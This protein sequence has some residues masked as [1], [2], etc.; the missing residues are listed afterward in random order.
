[1]CLR[2]AR[3]INPTKILA[4]NY[5]QAYEVQIGCCDCAECRGQKQKE[6]HVRAYWQARE[7]IDNDGWMYFDTLTYDNQHLPHLSDFDH[8]VKRFS[9][10][11]FSC[12]SYEEIRLF[13]VNL[14]RQLDYYGY[15]SKDNLQYFVSS[16]YGSDRD[17]LA[18]G[19][20]K[21]ATMRPHYHILF[22]VK[23][24]CNLSPMKLSY[25]I[26]KCWQK[27]RTD[28]YMYHPEDS[29]YV[30]KHTYG[31]QFCNDDL[32]IRRV[33][34]YVTKYVLKD[35]QYNSMIINRLT[36]LYESIYGEDFLNDN[37]H[38]KDFETIY[39]K[40]SMF[41]RQ[42]HGFGLYLLEKEDFDHL[43]DGYVVLPDEFKVQKKYKLP[44]YY[45]YHLW[46]EK[47]RDKNGKLKYGLSEDGVDH[48]Y[49]MIDKNIQM[50]A[51]RMEEWTKNIIG[52]SFV[53]DDMFFNVK[54]GEYDLSLSNA[55]C[56]EKG[57]KLY[58]DVMKLMGGR[59]WVDYA[60]YLLLYRGRIRSEVSC[61]TGIADDEY[62]VKNNIVMSKTK[63]G[64]EYIAEDRWL[65]NYA[66]RSDRKNFRYNFVTT[67]DLGNNEEGYKK[68]Y[69]VDF[70]YDEVMQYY[71]GQSKDIR[72]LV[73][74]SGEVYLDPIMFKKLY[75]YDENSDP[76][77]KDFDKVAD[78]YRIGNIYISRRKQKLYDTK[79]E[80]KKKFKNLGVYVKNI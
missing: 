47:Y 16:E 21:K 56:Y 46:Y 7:Y 73:L 37:R 55:E 66:S 18:G 70:G 78:L 79:Q 61:R 45:K 51:E 43:Y 49:D 15:N 9:E 77:F 6:W 2:E 57:L 29:E 72:D 50:I 3:I 44:S 10:Y 14:R 8:R 13:L 58:N 68:H 31:K 76:S 39:R 64:K 4:K 22:F 26:D 11:D 53:I 27:G 62:V 35:A 65:Y 19:V 40:V 12:F 41:H 74:K 20:L 28:G 34:S 17:Y 25:F 42:S 32:T 59:S 80:L 33:V 69:L 63:D 30:S 24:G 71:A 36:K 1:M 23:S 5:N 60:K 48:E 54:T 52:N 75:C 38:K 67:K